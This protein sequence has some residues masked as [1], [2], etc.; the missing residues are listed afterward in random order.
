MDFRPISGVDGVVVA[1]ATYVNVLSAPEI[2]E[3]YVLNFADA[4]RCEVFV[5]G[6]TVRLAR[7]DLQWRLP[8]DLRVVRRADTPNRPTF[9]S[10][11]TT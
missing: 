6:T 3:D 10:G 1:R 7:G 5:R 11:C 2:F 4:G 9:R 8:G